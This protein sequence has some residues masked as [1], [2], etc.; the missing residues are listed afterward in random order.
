[1]KYWY[2]AYGLVISASSH[3]LPPP[4]DLPNLV[5][6]ADVTSGTVSACTD[7][8]EHLADQPHSGDDVAPLV[9]SAD[10]QRAAVSFVKFDVV[11]GLQQQVAELGV[12]DAFPVQPAADGVAVEHHVD[13]EVLADIAQELDR[14][15][16]RRPGEVV[17]HHRA[18]GRVVEIDEPL[19]LAADALGPL[20]DGVG[21]VE[22]AL[23]GVA[24]VADHPGRSAGQHDR[25]GA[26]PAGSAAGSATAPGARRAGSARSGRSRHRWS[27]DRRPGPRPAHRDRWTARSAPATA[28][29]R[30]SSRTHGTHTADLPVSVAGARHRRARAAAVR[31]HL[32]ASGQPEPPRPVG[33]LAD[34]DARSGFGER[35]S[36]SAAAETQLHRCRRWSNRSTPLSSMVIPSAE[37]RLPGPRASAAGRTDRPRRARA[38]SSPLVDRGRAQQ[39]RRRPPRRG[40]RRR[41][42]THGC[43]GCGRCRADRPGRT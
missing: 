3:R 39:H 36:R 2:Q 28:I 32:R 21:G 10:L 42:R 26:R 22:G 18:R 24:R 14:R 43:R 5:P 20:G 15:H 29:R 25:A 13:R 27:P 16:R 35:R 34:P 12:G 38:T 19:Q 1:M 40:R 41:W 9:G 4:V 11:V 33:G 7:R 23:A 6:S 17:R 31:R 30:G 8:A 37:H